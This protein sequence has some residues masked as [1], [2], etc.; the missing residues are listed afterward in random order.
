VKI[1]RVT[2]FAP[3]GEVY[4]EVTATCA[5]EDFV[6]GDAIVAQL[7]VLLS[8]LP[9]TWEDVRVPSD[10]AQSRFTFLFEDLDLA[11]GDPVLVR[12]VRFGAVLDLKSIKAP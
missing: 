9:P 10:Q 5:P 8:D 1:A 4:V 6:S 12:L 3:R 2:A 11:S 7:E